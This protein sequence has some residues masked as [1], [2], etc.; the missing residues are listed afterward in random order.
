MK[1]R[2]AAGVVVRGLQYFRPAPAAVPR[3]AAWAALK[4]PLLCPTATRPLPHIPKTCGPTCTRNRSERFQ[5]MTV[6]PTHPP[7]SSTCT[8]S[9]RRG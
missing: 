9:P 7:G 3:P 5:I 6:H 4:Q 1:S 2:G 8:A